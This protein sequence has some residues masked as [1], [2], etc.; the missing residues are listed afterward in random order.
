MIAIGVNT[1]AHELRRFGEITLVLISS[2]ASHVACAFAPIPG[3][4]GVGR[5]LRV[6]AI[7]SWSALAPW[8]R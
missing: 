6:A 3:A 5:V 4:A 1:A 7:V 8:R 2:G